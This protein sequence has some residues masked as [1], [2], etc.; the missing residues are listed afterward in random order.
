MEEGVQ[1]H[2]CAMAKQQIDR[3]DWGWVHSSFGAKAEQTHRQ[4]R[5]HLWPRYN[6]GTRLLYI[7]NG[8]GGNEKDH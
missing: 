7:C 8:I 5:Q 6:L 3:Q 2:F 1:G 4:D